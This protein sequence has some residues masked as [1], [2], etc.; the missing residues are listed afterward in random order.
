MIKITVLYGHL[1]DA[2]G[3]EQYYSNVHLPLA[4]TMPYVAKAEFTKFL[5]RP[6]GSLPPYYRMAELYFEDADKMQL[7]LASPE[8]QATAADL[9]NFATGGFTFFAGMIG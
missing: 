1:A 8:G 4:S 9:H 3:F 5:P 2:E 7:N 6:D